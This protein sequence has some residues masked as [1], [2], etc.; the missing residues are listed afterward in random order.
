MGLCQRSRPFPD[1]C[2]SHGSFSVWKLAMYGGSVATSSLDDMLVN[3]RQLKDALTSSIIYIHFNLTS[4]L[5]RASVF[6]CFLT[7]AF[8]LLDF[9]WRTSVIDVIIVRSNLHAVWTFLQCN[10]LLASMFNVRNLAVIKT[11]LWP[12]SVI[13]SW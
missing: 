8:L 9:L 11:L 4:N 2:S 1:V 7:E 5:H 3:S 6:G 13:S 10:S 12:D